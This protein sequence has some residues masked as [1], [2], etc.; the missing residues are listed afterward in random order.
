MK[1]LKGLRKRQKD[2]LLARIA[3]WLYGVGGKGTF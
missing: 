2:I 3:A 1:T